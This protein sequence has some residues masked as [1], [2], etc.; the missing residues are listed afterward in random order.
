LIGILQKTRDAIDEA[1]ALARG[2]S[3]EAIK[4]VLYPAPLAVAPAVVP[5]VARAASP[6]ERGP[7]PSIAGVAPGESTEVRRR[8]VEALG[9]LEDHRAVEPL[10]GALV[11][12]DEVVR[13]E[14]KKALKRTRDKL[15][16]AERARD[17]EAMR[18]TRQILHP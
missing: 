11:D 18:L 1:R 17:V 9:T 13:A 7:V 3:I 15:E 4:D 14:A 16:A 2:R 8:T 12:E 5:A 10:V 6:E